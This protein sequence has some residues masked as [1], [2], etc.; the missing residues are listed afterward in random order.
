MPHAVNFK[1]P[2]LDIRG[3]NANYDK[4]VWKERVKEASKNAPKDS[5][6]PRWPAGYVIFENVIKEGL[7][8]SG[9]LKKRNRYCKKWLIANTFSSVLYTFCA[10]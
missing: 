9:T 6:I 5:L 8:L 7:K 3:Q 1:N 4:A 10:I 2:P